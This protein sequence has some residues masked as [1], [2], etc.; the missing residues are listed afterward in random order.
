MGRRKGRGGRRG[1]E[2]KRM[3]EG[4]KGVRKR[5][6]GEFNEEKDGSGREQML[7]KW[8]KVTI[9]INAIIDCFCYYHYH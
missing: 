7:V 1:S 3:E 6:F 4:G 5:E 9:T 2:R 8:V